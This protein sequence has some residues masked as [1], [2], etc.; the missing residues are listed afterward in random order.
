MAEAPSPNRSGLDRP[1]ES[2]GDQT[3]DELATVLAADGTREGAV[4]ALQEAS[5]VDHD[6]H[7][8]P[9]LPLGE[10][11]ASEGMA[12]ADAVEGELIAARQTMHSRSAKLRPISLIV[13]AAAGRVTAYF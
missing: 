9:P 5:G 2:A 10:T 1:G 6:G 7:E 4:L 12:L 3:A 8:E 13:D 11:K